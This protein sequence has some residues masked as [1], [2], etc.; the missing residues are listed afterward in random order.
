MKLNNMTLLIFFVFAHFLS[1]VVF[2]E[3]PYFPEGVFDKEDKE[4]N[5]FTAKWYSEQLRA[6][7]EPSLLKLSRE[8]RPITAYRL[9]WLPSFHPAIS[10]RL[11]KSGDLIMLHLV[12]L[13]GTGGG[14]PGKISTKK[15]KKLTEDEWTW[16]LI[17]LEKSR[18]W[19]ISTSPKEDLITGIVED[20]DQLICE[21]SDGGK[22]HIV[23]RS[24]PDP[25]YEKLCRYMLDLSGLDV[26]ETWEEYHG[27]DISEKP[28]E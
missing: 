11:V 26:K 13:D 25:G 15:S 1:S 6:M 18:Y 23:D 10:V 7:G 19:K 21:G 12:K 24:N 20:G 16:L 22:Y 2:A 5:D 28:I 27:E 14:E 8:D 17:Y 3:E 4:S 9:L